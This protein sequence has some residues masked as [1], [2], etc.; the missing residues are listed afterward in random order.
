MRS[1]SG[2][3]V[4]LSDLGGKVVIESVAEWC[5]FCQ[6]ESANELDKI[7]AEHPDVKVIQI[8][9]TGG[10]ESVEAFYGSIGKGINPNITVLYGN[11]EINEWLVS[12]GSTGYPY[13]HFAMDGKITASNAGYTESTFFTDLCSVAYGGWANLDQLVSVSGEKL[14]D[15]ARMSEIAREYQGS[16][17]EIEVPVS[18]INER[19]ERR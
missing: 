4:N 1:T 12:I 10:S 9:T 2:S 3:V 6:Q 19:L 18:F 7:V 13:F 16:L 5:G 15:I 14:S 8:M 17:Q 11:N